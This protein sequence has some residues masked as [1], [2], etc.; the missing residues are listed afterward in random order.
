MDTPR[1]DSTFRELPLTPD[2]LREVEHY[3]HA[4]QRLC[5]EWDTPELDAMLGD[6]LSPPEVTD[7]EEG[8]LQDSMASERSVAQGEESSEIDLLSSERDNQH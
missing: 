5:A 1:P 2:Q 4:R 8:L 7:E 6:M 3:I